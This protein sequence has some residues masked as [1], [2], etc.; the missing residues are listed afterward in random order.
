MS[1][2]A[3]FTAR[4]TALAV[5][6]ALGRKVT[7]KMVRGFVRDTIAAY[8]DG[9]Y[10]HH[11]YSAALRDRIVAGM[12]ARSKGARPAAASSGR[13]APTASAPKA[14]DPRGAAPRPPKAPKARA[15]LAGAQARQNGRAQA[16]APIVTVETP[17]AS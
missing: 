17:T 6:K 2:P 11:A 4:D 16:P 7:D 8:D 13:K 3:T 15:A 10:T 1:S 5:S 9:T 12:V 14:R